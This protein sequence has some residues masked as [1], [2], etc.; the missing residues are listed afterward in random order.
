MPKKSKK[1]IPDHPIGCPPSDLSEFDCNLN[2][3]PAKELDWGM[4]CIL[5]AV[6]HEPNNPEIS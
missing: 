5:P 1:I 2:L 3:L 6:L 4:K